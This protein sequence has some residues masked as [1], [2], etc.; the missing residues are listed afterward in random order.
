LIL[1]LLLI[2]GYMLIR[3][4]PGGPVL[5]AMLLCKI[6]TLGSALVFMNLFAG[7]LVS[8]ETFLWAVVVVVAAG[9]L[10]VGERRMGPVPAGWLRPS[11]WSTVG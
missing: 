7:S 11:L 1:P 3:G 10:V 2:T 5:A 8:G 6:V 9:W 4:R